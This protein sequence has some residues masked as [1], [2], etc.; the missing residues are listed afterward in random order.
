MEAASFGIPTIATDVGGSSEIVLD[1]VNGFLI[2]ENF[3]NEDLKN[4]IFKYISLSHEQ[5]IN[6]KENARKHWEKNFSADNNYP[7]FFQQ[8]DE[9]SE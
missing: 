1:G 8:Y 4:I 9:L 2:S 5:K 7:Q 3:T 6:L